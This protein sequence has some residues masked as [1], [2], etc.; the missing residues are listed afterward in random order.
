ML[1]SVSSE[2]GYFTCETAN[3]QRFDEAATASA[4]FTGDRQVPGFC[5]KPRRLFPCHHNSTVWYSGC[6][7]RRSAGHEADLHR[8][9]EV[10]EDDFLHSNHVFTLVWKVFL[11]IFSRNDPIDRFFTVPFF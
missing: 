8:S 2:K 3:C 7:C 1:C 4:H 6:D 11:L 9:G 10:E 5:I